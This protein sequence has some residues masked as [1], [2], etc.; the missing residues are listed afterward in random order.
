[1][2]ELT[3]RVGGTD[4]EGVLDAVLPALPGGVHQREEDGESE[5]KITAHPGTPSEEEI[6]AL[7]GDALLD[8]TAAD[9]SDD[10]RERRLARYEPL[11]VAERFL[12]RPKWAP[13]RGESGLIEIALGESAAFGTGIHP[14]T[15]SCLAALGSL[16]PLGSLADCGC[17]SGVLAIAA[18]LLGFSPV[19]AIDVEETSL[20]AGREN[21]SLN[22]VEVEIRRVDLCAEAPPVADTLV[23]NVPPVIQLELAANLERPPAV[24]IASGFTAEDVADVAHA[25]SVHG[26]EVVEEQRAMEWSTLVMR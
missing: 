4:L 25:W 20:A 6:R 12:V 9:I 1:V 10:W 26:L 11:V 21:A 2:L 23:A 3:L 5:L 24:A 22:G 13:E 15:Q 19:F 14:T 16:E 18:A 17:G 8:L 7:A